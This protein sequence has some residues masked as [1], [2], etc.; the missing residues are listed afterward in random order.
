VVENL[1][2]LQLQPQF[3]SPERLLEGVEALGQFL[4]YASADDFA[5]HPA[6]IAEPPKLHQVEQRRCRELAEIAMQPE[7]AVSVRGQP[8]FVV[9]TQEQYQYMR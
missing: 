3:E 7:V 2:D 4:N 9:M 6:P 8:K 1:S 5:V